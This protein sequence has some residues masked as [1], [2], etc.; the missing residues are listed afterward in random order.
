MGATANPAEV[1]ELLRQMGQ[2]IRLA[3]TRRD[4][5]IAEIAAK[6]HLDRNTVNTLELGK[7]CDAI[8]AWM[9]VLCVL[10]LDRTL[11]R[12]AHP[13][14][15]PHGRTLEASRRPQRVRRKRVPSDEYDF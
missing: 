11:E 7:P 13:D 9:T 8:S 10:A 15:D 6:A 1:S 12:G 4:L 5:T 2:R 14:A 3:R